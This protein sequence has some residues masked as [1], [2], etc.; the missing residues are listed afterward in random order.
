M[1]AEDF[2]WMLQSTPG[3]YVWLGTGNGSVDQPGLHNP[4][5]DFNDNVLETGARFWIELVEW[6]LTEESQH[7]SQG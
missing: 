2:A 6:S 5:Y 1:G 4:N 3:S 7:A